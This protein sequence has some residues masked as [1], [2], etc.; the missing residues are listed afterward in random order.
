[1]LELVV[2]RQGHSRSSPP[3]S[4][5][6]NRRGAVTAPPAPSLEEA[7]A[8][9]PLSDSERRDL[10]REIALNRALAAGLRL[11]TR[12]QAPE[13]PSR[14]ITRYWKKLSRTKPPGTICK[15]CRKPLPHS[16]NDDMYWHFHL[17]AIRR[18]ATFQ[19]AKMSK[20]ERAAF[21]VSATRASMKV[22]FDDR[23]RDLRMWLAPQTLRVMGDKDLAELVS[24]YYASKSTRFYQWVRARFPVTE[25][26][27]RTPRRRGKK[28]VAH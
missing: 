2:A 23:I 20:A 21:L 19:W 16:T 18:R 14:P 10:A 4:V 15:G 8:S 12:R 5:S 27:P 3:S 24:K 26:C 9:M 13:P 22:R 25:A 17:M 1:M 28:I 7:L 6:P 11:R